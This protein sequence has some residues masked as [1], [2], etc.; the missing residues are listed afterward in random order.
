MSTGM[1]GWPG[2]L[3]AE[4]LRDL[5]RRGHVIGTHS[6]SHPTRFSACSRAEMAA[7]WVDSRKALEDLLGHA[8]TIGSL[9]GGYLS[10]AV[11]RSANESGLEWLFTSEPETRLRQVGGCTLGGRFTIRPDHPVEFARDIVADRASARRREWVQWHLKKI[12]KPV[13][14]P[15]YPAIGAWLRGR[16]D[17]SIALRQ[18]GSE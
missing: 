17:A 15:A 8:V 9:P 16:Q 1:I 4:H 18:G 6:V 2:F 7:E 5:D 14:G 10:R 12:V 13:L 3:T 11:A